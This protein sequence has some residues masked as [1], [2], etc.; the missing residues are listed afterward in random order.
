MFTHFTADEYILFYSSS[1]KQS[2]V[3]TC[4]FLFCFCIISESK[5]AT[6]MRVRVCVWFLSVLWIVLNLFSQMM[7]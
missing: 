6:S 5:V 3:G 4:G 7:K 1:Y 2:A